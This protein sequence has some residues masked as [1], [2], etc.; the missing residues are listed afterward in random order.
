MTHIQSFRTQPA[1]APESKLTAIGG[2]TWREGTPGFRFYTEVLMQGPA[3]V[4]EAIEKAAALAEPFSEKAVQGHLRWMF[5]SAGELL[6]VDG[7]KFAEP[8]KAEPVKVEKP[9]PVKAPKAKKAKA[10]KLAA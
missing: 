8:V 9:K 4:G 1:F 10:V 6:E 5:T 3:T 2:N 7:Q